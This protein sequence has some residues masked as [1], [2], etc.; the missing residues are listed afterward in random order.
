MPTRE[1]SLAAAAAAGGVPDYVV[2]GARLGVPPGQAY[3]IATGLAADGS[4]GL[5]TADR[6][7][8]GVLGTSTQHLANPPAHNPTRDENVVRWV[9]ERGRSTLHHPE[10]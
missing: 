8:P 3:L 7:R 10:G 6:A 4:G 9:A 2:A 1:Q 5:A